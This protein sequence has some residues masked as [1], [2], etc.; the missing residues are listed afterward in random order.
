MQ[1]ILA[2]TF[3]S[4]IA[5]GYLA[6]GVLIVPISKTKY[7]RWVASERYWRSC[8]RENWYGEEAEFDPIWFIRICFLPSLA[9]LKG[10]EVLVR[11]YW[12]PSQSTL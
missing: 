12:K 9:L 4:L 5:I 3:V 7:F 8:Q 1:F 6:G 2:V 10:I 11:K